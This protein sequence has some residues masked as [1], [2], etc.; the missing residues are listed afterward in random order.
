MSSIHT[1]E[2]AALGQQNRLAAADHARTV[3]AAR[4]GTKPRLARLP[5]RLPRVRFPSFGWARSRVAPRA[6]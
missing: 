1:Y 2:F 5:I 6:A 4:A 3:S